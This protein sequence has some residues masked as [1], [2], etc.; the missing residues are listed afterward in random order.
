MATLT[1][2]FS[3]KSAID[4]SSQT[5]IWLEFAKNTAWT[6]ENNPDAENSSTT[7][8][9]T[10]Q[11]FVKS[12]A[13]VLLYPASDTDNDDNVIIYRKMRW[14]PSSPSDAFTNNANYVLISYK[15]DAGTT[16]DFSWRQTGIRKGVTPVDSSNTKTIL[17]PSEVS[18]K[19]KLLGFDNHKVQNYTNDV[20]T[21]LE[22]LMEF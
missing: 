13:L 16:D 8:L 5:D 4:F 6:D 18:D 22:Y 11:L 10:S 14:K 20:V 3:V 19:G 9:D 7:S 2:Y 15:I 1:N 12:N 17:K 21:D